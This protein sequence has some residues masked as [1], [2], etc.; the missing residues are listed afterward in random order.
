MNINRHNY[1]EY[2][3][4]YMDNELGSEDRRSVEEFVVLHPDLKEELDILLQSKLVPD[5]S[6]LFEGKDELM[7]F[8]DPS[9]A[10]NMSNYEEWFVMYMDNELND[11]ERIAVER[12]AENNPSIKE[13][14]NLFLK[15]KLQPET[16]VF[17]NKES[18]YRR[19]EKVR[20]IPVWWR[21]AAAAA[22]VITVGITGVVVLNNK[23]DTA[24]ETANANQAEAKQATKERPEVADNNTKQT[25]QPSTTD[26]NLIIQPEKIANS[27]ILAKQDNK[28]SQS[29][30]KIQNNLPVQVKKE[31]ELIANNNLPTPE[32]N[33]NVSR[34]INPVDASS[35]ATAYKVNEADKMSSQQ[36]SNNLAV[37][38]SPTY[39]YNKQIIDEPVDES[40]GKK[41]KLRG[42]FRKITRTFEKR[43]GIDATDD[44]NRL[45]VAGLAIKLK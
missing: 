18:L 11:E 10:I 31:E 7:M 34:P 27:S 21:V 14:L 3:I 1:E 44:D 26:N 19:E 13:E 23:P 15:T 41:N 38:V 33:P 6:I 17:A 35:N 42:F 4:L 29:K 9:L 5:N 28:N 32:N 40:D 30:E 39:A 16:I 36:N 37:T 2:F 8:S 24:K 25:T 12:F 20:R 43:T 45:L 22:I